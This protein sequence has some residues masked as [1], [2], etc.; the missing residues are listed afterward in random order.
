MACSS[1]SAASSSSSSSILSLVSLLG[2]MT[3]SLMKRPNRK[4]TKPQIQ[5]ST[6]NHQP[7]ANAILSFDVFF[8]CSSLCRQIGNAIPASKNAMPIMLQNLDVH[9]QVQQQQSVTSIRSTSNVLLEFSMT[10]LLLLLLPL[11]LACL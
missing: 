9:L 10:L 5:R 11:L 7:V 6:T 8:S 4:E 3:H 1:S 2:L